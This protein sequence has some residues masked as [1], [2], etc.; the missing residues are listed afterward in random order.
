MCIRSL[1]RGS[2]VKYPNLG[3]SDLRINFARALSPRWHMPKSIRS[4]RH[5]RLLEILIEERK[6]ADL[7]QAVLAE[8][9]GRPQS[10]VA[11]Y[12]NG[13]RRIDV[14]EFVALA[15]AFGVAPMALLR[16][17]VEAMGPGKEAKSGRTPRCRRPAKKSEI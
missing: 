10:Y 8:R 13:E 2:P 9:L 15:R 4:P 7:T 16:R 11:K 14:I 17:F 3:L 5:Q 12:E 6:R 1:G